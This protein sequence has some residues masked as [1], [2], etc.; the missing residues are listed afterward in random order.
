MKNHITVLRNEAVEALAIKPNSIIVDA[1]VG[2]GGHT[3]LILD[4]L[5]ADSTFVGIDADPHAIAEAR[6]RFTKTNATTHFQ[7]G[8]FRHL[9]SILYALKIE[10]VNGIVADLGWRMEQFTAGGRGFSFQVDEPLTMTFGDPKS[11]AFTAQDIVNEWKEDD[12]R[13]VIRGYGEERFAGRIANAIVTARRESPIV[14]SGQLANIITDAVPGFYKRGKI[15]P[16]TRTFQAL[17]IAVND[18]FEA[19]ETFIRTALS[20]LAPSGRLAIITFHSLEDRIVKHLFR[21]YAHDQFGTVLT[22][23]PIAPT[24]EEINNNPRARSAKLRIFE[25]H[26]YQE[27]Q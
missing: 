26:A 9:D 16:A 20:H 4:A 14:T 21:S 13:N 18:E 5:D 22:K 2:S 3:A 7:V 8:N 25:K 17:R 12:I 11:Y 23:K 27:S 1:T 10:A 19:L 24:S 6:A 15:H